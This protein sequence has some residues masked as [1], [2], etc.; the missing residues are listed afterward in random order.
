[1]GAIETTYFCTPHRGS[2][3]ML[4]AV[5]RQHKFAIKVTSQI[6]WKLPSG[7][8]HGIRRYREFIHLIQ[9]SPGVVAVPTIDIGK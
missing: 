3:D 2:I 8:I 6:D 7:I 1:M 5:A 4:M 9:C